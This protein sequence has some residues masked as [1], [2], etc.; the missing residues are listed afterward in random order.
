MTHKEEIEKFQKGWNTFMMD[1]SKTILTKKDLKTFKGL[2]F[3]PIN[4]KYK[5]EADFE[6]TLSTP[7]FEM[8]TTTDRLP[9]YRKYGYVSFT[10]EGKS[11]KVPVYE[12]QSLLKKKGYEDY[13][14]FPFTDLT[15]GKT[16]YYGGRYI[17]LKVPKGDKIIIDFNKAYNPYCTY[18][19]K[20]SCP[21][22]PKENDLAIEIKAG[23]KKYKK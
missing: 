12:Q 1:T 4:K 21:I 16:S 8:K 19:P 20:Y 9:E 18:N 11:F 14:F 3:F 15:N 5:V 6:K 7:I 2:D 13:L 17:G 10:L 22:P 23:F